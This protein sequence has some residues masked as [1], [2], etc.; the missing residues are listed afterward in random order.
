MFEIPVKE[1]NT[2]T[3]TIFKNPGIL[4]EQPVREKSSLGSLSRWLLNITTDGDS[5]TFLGF[6]SSV[7]LGNFNFFFFFTWDFFLP[8]MSS[9][10]PLL[11]SVFYLNRPESALAKHLKASS[12]QDWKHKTFQL[13]SLECGTACLAWLALFKSCLFSP[14]RAGAVISHFFWTQSWSGNTSVP[15]PGKSCSVLQKT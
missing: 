9:E 12:T 2:I 14:D 15:S 5:S 4:A 8:Y 13:E 10:S 7:E 11:S 1:I 6:C 3:T